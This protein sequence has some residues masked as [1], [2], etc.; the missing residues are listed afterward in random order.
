MIYEYLGNELE[1]YGKMSSDVPS[2]QHGKP[3][4]ITSDSAPRGLGVRHRPA[5][6][7]SADTRQTDQAVIQNPQTVQ[8]LLHNVKASLNANW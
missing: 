5:F 3:Y 2:F 6:N 7:T 8:Q 1:T 4:P